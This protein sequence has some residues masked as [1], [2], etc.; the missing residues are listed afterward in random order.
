MQK[1]AHTFLNLFM[2]PNPPPKV[3]LNIVPSVPD[4]WPFYLMNNLLPEQDYLA[5]GGMASNTE[6]KLSSPCAQVRRPGG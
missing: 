6:D 5:L 4:A 3:V 1:T 2:K